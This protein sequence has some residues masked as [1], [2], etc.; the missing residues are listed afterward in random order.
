MERQQ[1][2]PLPP[3]GSSSAPIIAAFDP[4]IRASC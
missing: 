2:V 3:M 1:H 4:S